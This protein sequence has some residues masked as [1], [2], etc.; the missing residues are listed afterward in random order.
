MPHSGLLHRWPPMAPYP[1]MNG[2]MAATP[3]TVVSPFTSICVA[4][5]SDAH[6]LS[7]VS[8]AKFGFV[9]PGEGLPPVAVRYTTAPVGQVKSWVIS[10]VPSA[11]EYTDWLKS[12]VE[13]AKAVAPTAYNWIIAP[14]T[15]C[16][17]P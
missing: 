3:A 8:N 1:V 11:A 7:I 6:G 16:W 4:G 2:A 9:M 10:N 5:V 12:T 13:R 15:C 17:P 14:E